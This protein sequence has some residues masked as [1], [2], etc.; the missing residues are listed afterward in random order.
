MKIAKISKNRLT[1]LGDSMGFIPYYSAIGAVFRFVCK[2]AKT[3]TT[4]VIFNVLLTVHHAVIL[5]NVQLD[6][7]IPFNI[8]IYL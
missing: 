6:A 5:G 2:T 3:T 7:Q 4:F 8:F 1:L